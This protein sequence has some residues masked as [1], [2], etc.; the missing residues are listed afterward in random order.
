M[1]KFSEK[2]YQ[3]IA[4]KRFCGPWSSPRGPH[5]P[6]LPWI[7]YPLHPVLREFFLKH[8]ERVE[9]PPN[10]C[11]FPTPQVTGFYYLDQGLSGRIASTL[12]GQSG[13]GAI[14][15]STTYRF[16]A[17]NLNWATRRPAIGRYI[18][19]SNCILYGISHVQM[20]ALLHDASVEFL[21]I[22]FTQMEI[23]NLCDRQGFALLALMN[24]A[25]RFEALLLSWAVYFGTI[26][27]VPGKGDIVVMPV[28]GRR[29]HIES[30]IGASSVTLDKIVSHLVQTA[31]YIRS[32]E[33]ISFK[34]SQL[35]AAHDWMCHSDGEDCVLY[36]RPKRVE[37]MLYGAQEGLYG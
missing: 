37:D 36:P 26:E 12:D 23:M 16:A 33:F 9:L 10:R 14:A 7:G 11:I 3:A 6:T 27:N 34:A 17:G 28:P 35:Q 2:W 31:G 25:V 15:Y 20:E 19:I 13:V 22:L 29:L 32:G 24:A 30:A 21:K 8:G 4:T 18:T 5:L 1:K